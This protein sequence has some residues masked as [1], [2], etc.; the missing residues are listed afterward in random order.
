MFFKSLFKKDEKKSMFKNVDWGG[1]VHLYG[2][3]EEGDIS[4]GEY[5]FIGDN[6]KITK[7]EIGRYCSVGEDVCISPGEHLIDA[8]STSAMFYEEPWDVLTRKNV[9]I[10]DDVWIG[11]RSIILGGVKIGN[12]AIIAAG[13]VVTKDVP[14]F[15]VYGG[16]PAKFIKMRFPE[17]KIKIILDSKWWE[18]PPN[19]AKIIIRSLEKKMAEFA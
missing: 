11:T 9:V 1:N 3:V 10:G 8:V 6:T 19:E 7:A 13:A 14:P 2:H 18:Y 17:V 12:G 15:A 16:V 4:I 5:T